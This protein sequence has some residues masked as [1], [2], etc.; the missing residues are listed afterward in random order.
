MATP[1]KIN[2]TYDQ[3]KALKQSII[4][5]NLNDS[6]KDLIHGLIDFNGWLQQQLLEKRIS[7]SRL[8]SIIFG[9]QGI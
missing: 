9:S 5:S 6:D 2:L 3:V 7:I 1:K 8:K 4:N